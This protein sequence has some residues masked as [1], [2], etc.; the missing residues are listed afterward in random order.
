LR[1]TVQSGH[2]GC[3]YPVVQGGDPAVLGHRRRREVNAQYFGQ[4]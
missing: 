3:E 2:R 4:Q 1:L